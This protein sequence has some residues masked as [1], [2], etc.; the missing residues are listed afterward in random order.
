MTGRR[1]TAN[2]VREAHCIRCDRWTVTSLDTLAQRWGL[3]TLNWNPA[4]YYEGICHTCAGE[5]K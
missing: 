1:I 2:A 5:T 4:G 3:T